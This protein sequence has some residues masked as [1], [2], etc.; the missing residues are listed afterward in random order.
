MGCIAKLGG[1]GNTTL[2]QQEPPCAE[3]CLFHLVC[4]SKG[5]R[6]DIIFSCKC[7]EDCDGQKLGY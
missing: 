2:S 5:M 7:D 6:R 3:S 4:I 1:G